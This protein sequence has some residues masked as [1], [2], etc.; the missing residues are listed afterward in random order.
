MYARAAWVFNA[1]QVDGY[2][3]PDQQP[4]SDLTTRLAHVD[5]FIAAT[6]ADFREGGGRAFYRRKTASGEGDYIQMPPRDLFTGTVTLTPTEAY[7]STR[8][9]EL[10]HWAGAEH[11]LNRQFGQRFGDDQYAI[12]E[13]VAELSASFLCAELAITNTPRPDHAQYLAHWLTVLKA[14]NRAIF[15]AASQASRATQYLIRFQP[16]F[17]QIAA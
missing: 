2:T 17:Q 15:T 6:G 8:L 10:S 4:R 3:L 13:L 1:A 16:A 14:D 9:H 5:T 7:E 11:R 12:E